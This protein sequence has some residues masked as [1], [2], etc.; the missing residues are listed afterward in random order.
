LGLLGPVVISA[1]GYQPRFNIK[2][3]CSVQ[4]L[5]QKQD[6]GGLSK[7]KMFVPLLVGLYES[8]FGNLMAALKRLRWK[9]FVLRLLEKHASLSGNPKKIC[10]F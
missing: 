9:T 6:I 10:R 2:I 7:I 5:F 8:F 1:P 3:Q 4:K